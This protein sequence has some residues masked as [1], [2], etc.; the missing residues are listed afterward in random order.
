VTTFAPGVPAPEIA[1]W[2]L[3]EALVAVYAKIVEEETGYAGAWSKTTKYKAGEA[4]NGVGAHAGFIYVCKTENENHE[5]PN[6]TYWE[7]RAVPQTYSLAIAPVAL[8]PDGT[9]FEG[10]G[11][12]PHPSF[13]G[14]S[15]DSDRWITFTAPLEQQ[16]TIASMV[17]QLQEL[18]Y[19][20]GFD[21]AVDVSRDD[22][23]A[24]QAQISMSYPKRGVDEPEASQVLELSQ[25]LE[26]EY[27]EE[28]SSASNLT[29]SRAGGATEELATESPAPEA[30][31]EG[32]PLLQQVGT[33]PS[34][35]KST[36]PIAFLDA[37]TQGLTATNAY[38]LV[39]ATV[40]VPMFGTPSIFDL[41]VGDPVKL[42]IPRQAGGQEPSGN[43][44][45]P[46]G[47]PPELPVDGEA[48]YWRV[49]RIDVAVPDEGVPTMKLTLTLPLYEDE[50]THEQRPIQPPADQ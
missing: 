22:A 20:Y 10:E 36:N 26:F 23:G 15:I 13:A 3:S 33:M 12:E 6:A 17:T 40:T 25:A 38:P 49:T 50:E 34:L 11:D 29:I 32:Y 1:Y 43:P 30:W 39:T 37:F 28:G 4:V 7:Q 45:F 21:F 18:G 27:D 48:Y 41:D 47:F 31:E 14:N 35:A 42:I 2:V 24:P 19:G 44:R 9:P 16:Q 5:P 46:E 8:A